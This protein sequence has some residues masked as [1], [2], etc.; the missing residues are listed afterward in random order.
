MN[1]NSDLYC[2]I[3]V[4]APVTREELAALVLQIAGAENVGRYLLR[5]LSAE[6]E[7]RPNE[8]ANERLRG[9]QENGFLYYP[10]LLEVD[11]LP[12]QSIEQQMALVS[13]ILELLWAR[14]FNAVAACDFEDRLPRNGR[15]A[16]GAS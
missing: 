10:Y 11:A 3:Y 1:D 16:W 4:N 5:L 9:S 8:D 14:Q 12:G 13:A 15:D 6:V 7:V 2:A